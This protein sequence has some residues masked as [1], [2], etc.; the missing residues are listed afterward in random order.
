MLEENFIPDNSIDKVL[1][2]ER[3]ESYKHDGRTVFGKAKKPIQL[4]LF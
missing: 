1:E 2:H 4:R 3:N